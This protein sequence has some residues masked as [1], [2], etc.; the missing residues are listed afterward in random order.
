MISIREDPIDVNKILEE[1]RDDSAGAIAFFI[2]IVRDHNEGK[3]VA[4]IH[5]E[6]YKEMAEKILLEIEMEATKK[7]N[8]KKIIAVHRIGD[9][10]IGDISV[11]VAVST[12][13]RKEAFE[14][15]RY[16]I[17][18]IKTRVP[19]WKKEKSDSG[20]HWLENIPA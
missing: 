5:Y 11:I 7:W 15:C 19:I 18:M 12:E 4:G 8:I 2:G 9:L 6:A 10:N 20:E 16:A 13:H 14:A 3:R 1:T 17:D